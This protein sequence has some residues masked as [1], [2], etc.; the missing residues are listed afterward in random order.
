MKIDRLGWWLASLG[1]VFA[2]IGL[3]WLTLPGIPRGA[4]VFLLGGAVFIAGGVVR[5]RAEHRRRAGDRSP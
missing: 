4:V 3:W 1:L 5:W 2:F